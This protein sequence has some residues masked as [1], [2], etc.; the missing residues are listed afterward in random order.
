MQNPKSLFWRLLISY[1]LVIA[2]GSFTLYVVGQT[3][4]PLLLKQHITTMMEDPHGHT[5]DAQDLMLTDLELAYSK[6][7]GQSLAWSIGIAAFVASIIVLFVTSRLV[8][9]LR[10]M[11]QASQRIAAGHYEERLAIQSSDEIGDLAKSFNAMAS[12]LDKYE[13]RRIELLANLAHEFKTPINNI[14]GYLDGLEDGLFTAKAETYGAMQRQLGRLEHLIGDLS[15]LSR[16]ESGVE[17]IE[18]KQVDLAKLIH[19]AVSEFQAQYDLKG[20]KLENT[21]HDDVLMLQADT[22]RLFQVFA[23]LLHNALRHTSTDGCVRI[24]CSQDSDTITIT[25]SDSGE[26]IPAEEQGYIFNRFYRVDKSR[27]HDG[28]QS[29]GIGLT[30]AKHFVEMHGG[31][32]Y[33]KASSNQGSI[34]ELT[35]PKN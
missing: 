30:I 18:L 35:L 14:K 10:L 5:A 13:H 15:L 7:L 4:A 21:S 26:G 34:F 22:N 31:K 2:A 27:Q 20:V 25:V 9:P 12:T 17:K 19:E 1:L 3:F 32:L 6:A 8:T 29:S 16:V 28:Q 11:K 24:S 33:L 23:N